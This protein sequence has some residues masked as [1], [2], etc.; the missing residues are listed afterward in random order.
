MFRDCGDIGIMHGIKRRRP[1][2]ESLPARARIGL[3]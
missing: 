2:F 1:L 3:E